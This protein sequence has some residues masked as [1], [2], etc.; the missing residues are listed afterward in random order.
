MASLVN[1]PNGT[2]R[3][4][5]L[6]S[7]RKRKTIRL[8]KISRKDAESIRR[9]VEMILAAQLSGQPLPRETA[10]WLDAIGDL[11]AEKL[12]A[13]GL[14]ERDEKIPTV[15]EFTE[16]WLAEKA[17]E[18]I[19]KGTIRMQRLAASVMVELFGGR[20]ISKIT[21]ADSER[22]FSRIA[23]LKASTKNLRLS[24]A[25]AILRSAARQFGFSPPWDNIVART[26]EAKRHTYV[27]ISDV[28]LVIG[29]CPD[30]WWRL[31][32]AL[33]RFAGLR[34][35][36]EP[37]AL[38]WEDVNWERQRFTVGSPKTGIRVVPIFPLLR[39]YLNAAWEAAEPGA[40]YVLPRDFRPNPQ[41]G[42]ISIGCAIRI[43]FMRMIR[44]AGFVPWRQPWHALRASCESDL[45][46][47]FPLAI[48]AKW[49]GNS[50]TVAMRH[51]IDTTDVSFEAAQSWQGPPQSTQK[52]AQ[53]AAQP[54]AIRSDIYEHGGNENI[55]NL[56]EML[57]DDT[58]DHS[59]SDHSGIVGEFVPLAIP[60]G[61][62]V[63]LPPGGAQSGAIAPK[64]VSQAV[65]DQL[66][67]DSKSAIIRD[68]LG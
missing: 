1:D 21:H 28:E 22:F 68:L 40:E 65:W 53:K 33:A 67:A 29:Q 56:G 36:S 13:V 3:I 15:R 4:Q 43:A 11:L 46:A 10:V 26:V 14:I 20:I 5:F 31:L 63:D 27:T 2:R 52:A 19:A 57:I 30:V 39:P 55:E 61:N 58:S 44:R 8:G 37:F 66:S 54:G 6:S 24:H 42:K 48:V 50:P 38:R 25:K 51:Y 34:T 60:T 17:A 12:E 47:A 7:D 45:A 16:R 62:N 9:H 41:L 59:I 32:V 18:G 23:N 35:P 64:G 49:L